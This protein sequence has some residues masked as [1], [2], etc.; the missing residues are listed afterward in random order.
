ML[1]AWTACFAAEAD[2][3]VLYNGNTPTNVDGLH[4]MTQRFA[5]QG[6][7]R[8]QGIRDPKEILPG[9]YKAIVVLSTGLSSGVDRNL[10]DFIASWQKKSEIILVSLKK[11]T[12][13]LSVVQYPPSPNNLG[14]DAVTA[15]SVWTGKGLAAIFGGKNSPEYEMHVDWVARVMALVDKMR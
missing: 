5:E 9:K 3:A 12:K 14:V 7:H 4:F 10:A 2:V 13:D 6:L 8:V 1:L 15:A 11:G